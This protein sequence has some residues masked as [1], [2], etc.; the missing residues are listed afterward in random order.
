MAC[1]RIWR[2][3]ER[4]LVSAGSVG[5]LGRCFGWFGAALFV[6]GTL[7]TLSEVYFRGK[8]MCG[9]TQSPLV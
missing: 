9:F 6:S 1:V 4:I 7:L 3:R 5:A 2:V 8:Q